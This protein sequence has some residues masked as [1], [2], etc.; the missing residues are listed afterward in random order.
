MEVISQNKNSKSP[1]FKVNFDHNKCV[2]RCCV[3]KNPNDDT[4]EVDGVKEETAIA[5][6]VENPNEEK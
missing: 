2:L 1:S 3:F 4:D 6:E 5:E